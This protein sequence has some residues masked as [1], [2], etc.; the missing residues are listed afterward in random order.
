MYLTFLILIRF[1]ILRF[2]LDRLIFSVHFNHSRDFAWS[3]RNVML[4]D[5]TQSALST[6][7]AVTRYDKALNYVKQVLGMSHDA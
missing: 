4:C 2:S 3:G 7:C 1:E 5:W 6:N